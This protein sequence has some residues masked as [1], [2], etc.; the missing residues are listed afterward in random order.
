MLIFI[1]HMLHIKFITL[2]LTI[3]PA[4][5]L[6]SFSIILLPIPIYLIPWICDICPYRIG[7]SMLLVYICQLIRK[8]LF[9]LS[10]RY[11]EFYLA[12]FSLFVIYYFLLAWIIESSSTIQKKIKNTMLL[13]LDKYLPKLPECMLQNFILDKAMYYEFVRDIWNQMAVKIQ[14][15]KRK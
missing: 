15:L 10:F 1:I 9:R 13:L 14:F 2:S 12:S 5:S 11:L 6:C 8:Y 3:N 7:F 4:S